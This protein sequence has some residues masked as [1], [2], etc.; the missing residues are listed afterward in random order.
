[1]TGSRL[2]KRLS[3]A[4]LGAFLVPACRGSGGG[5]PQ[6]PPFSWTDIAVSSWG[7]DS[8]TR[9]LAGSAHGGGV[10]DSVSGWG[11]PSVAIGPQGHPS[12]AWIGRGRVSFRR[13]NGLGWE[14]LGGSASGNGIAT[15]PMPGGLAL[16]LD[17]GGNPLVAWVQQ[18]PPSG[19]QIYLKRWDGTQWAELGNSASSGGLSNG[20]SCSQVCLAVDSIGNPVVA[21]VD[22]NPNDTIFLRRWDGLQWS[23]LGGSGSGGGVN[24]D[25]KSS[26]SP[27]MALDSG[28]R[29][30][31]CWST[32]GNVYLK[33][34]NGVSWTGLGGSETGS[35]LAT[36]G[37]AAPSVALDASDNPAVAWHSG[38]S[39]NSEIY[40]RQWDGLAW[41][42]LGGSASSGGIS[43]SA[44]DS[45]S[46]LIARS[47]AGALL[48]AWTENISGFSSIQFRIWTGVQWTQL[49]P[50]LP[51]HLWIG[52]SI[53]G[54]FPLVLRE[55][56]RCIAAW[57]SASALSIPLWDWN[58]SAWLERG[59]S[60]PSWGGL[61]HTSP[62]MSTDSP[63]IALNAQGNPYVA[64]RV[65]SN[66]S[67]T[68]GQIHLKQYNGTSWVELGGSATGSGVSQTFN[69]MGA[70]SPA[71]I[72]DGSEKPILCWSEFFPPGTTAAASIYLKRWDGAQWT[73]IGGSATGGGISG[74]SAREA[75]EP[76]IAIDIAGNPVVSWTAADSFTPMPGEIHLKQWDGSAWN[77]LGGSA[78]G[79]GISNSPGPDSTMP[80]VAVN[81][82]GEPYVVWSENGLAYLKKWNGLQWVELG[83]S[84][85]GFGLGVSGAYGP[86]PRVVLDQ[87][88]N[89]IVATA[90][91]GSIA[92]KRWDGT[93]W[94]TLGGPELSSAVTGPSEKRCNV[95][96][97][98]SQPGQP[99][100]AWTALVGESSEIH[101]RKWDGVTWGEH[102]VNSASGGGISN[103]SGCSTAPAIA[104]GGN[105]VAVAW[106]DWG[107]VNRDIYVRRAPA[108]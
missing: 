54:R 62:T 93:S 27:Y 48:L 1:M 74:S 67:P 103:A 102:G 99:I 63:R 78:T 65:Y 69:S 55:P 97:A 82:L 4:L 101:V 13:W 18:V 2:S 53:P 11:P 94:Q 80:S 16:A 7:V 61:S 107:E 46:P 90:S 106:S 73:P 42:E 64:W 60:S 43:S 52:N 30:V 47:A 71:L 68:N 10:S 86:G 41:T 58:G 95:A 17:G 38:V 50:D 51:T 83:G 28:D 3:I 14:E 49:A 81:A 100:L 33:K 12:V 89:P 23:E 56:D 25:G 44:D 20:V 59:V 79:G 98:I 29:P 35:G 32:N 9:V 22:S 40:L 34:W 88:G 21:W 108:P 6:A 36:S 8:G 75:Y 76:S 24:N 31:L 19:F 96:M 77:E 84:A 72:L 57:S 104:I 66:G 91:F 87:T 39:G 105:R 85:S 92:V 70:T 45:G 5:A 37:F 26:F 15:G